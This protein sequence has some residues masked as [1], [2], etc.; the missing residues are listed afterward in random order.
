MNKCKFCQE[1]L[2]EDSTVCPHCGKD[3][4][5][6]ETA[7]QTAEEAAS[8]G[9]TEETVTAEET[10]SAGESVSTEEG[11]SAEEVPRPPPA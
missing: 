2:A 8:A 1:E 6:E 5:E 9:S 11:V 7:T 4:A 10:A 3:N